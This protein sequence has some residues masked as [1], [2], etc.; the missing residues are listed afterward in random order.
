MLVDVERAIAIEHRATASRDAWRGS[1]LE[2]FTT[3]HNPE[4]VHV[5]DGREVSAVEEVALSTCHSTKPMR[6]ERSPPSE[7]RRA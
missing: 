4:P 2:T 7:N 6:A 5:R 3:S 1:K